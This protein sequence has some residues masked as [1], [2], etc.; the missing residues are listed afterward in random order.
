MPH[1]T[2][3]NTCLGDTVH[4]CRR[5][6]QEQFWILLY[7]VIQHVRTFTVCPLIISFILSGLTPEREKSTFL[8]SNGASSESS[9]MSSNF[10]LP[11]F[12]FTDNRQTIATPLYYPQ[13]T[14]KFDIG[15][16]SRLPL[17]SGMT[18]RFPFG[19]SRIFRVH[20][21]PRDPRPN[22][23]WERAIKNFNSSYQCPELRG[24]TNKKIYEMDSSYFTASITSPI[25][26]DVDFWH[27]QS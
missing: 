9:S 13:A 11:H 20:M 26:Y 16:C 14:A 1:Y 3:L 12:T 27:T 6:H 15:V 21:W 4:V 7:A 23:N 19:G 24:N 22:R 18:R 10:S 5:V 17:Y 8:N 2:C 25:I